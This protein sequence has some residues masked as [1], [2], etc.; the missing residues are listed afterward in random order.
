[1]TTLHGRLDHA[2]LQ[3]LY[4]E[5]SDIPVISVSKEQQQPL[6]HAGWS[7]AVLHGLPAG[8]LPAG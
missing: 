7:G 1:M 3:S 8:P 5:F 4:R 2:E 6:P